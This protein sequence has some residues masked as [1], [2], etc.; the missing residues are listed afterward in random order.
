MGNKIARYL[1]Y[2]S[3]FAKSH[4][5]KVVINNLSAE[6][7]DKGFKLGMQS[8]LHKNRENP[9]SR[10]ITKTIIMVPVRLSSL[11]EYI[12]Y[13]KNNELSDKRNKEVEE[14]L[15]RENGKEFSVKGYSYPA[16]AD[17][18]FLVDYLYSDNV[19]INWRERVICPITELNNRLRATVHFIDYELGINE[20]TVTYLAEQLTPLYNFLYKRHKHIIGSEFLGTGL[21][22][23][24][25]NENGIRHEDATNLSFPDA[26]VDCYLTFECLEHI[27]DYYKTFTEACRILKENGKLF[28]TVPFSPGSYENIIRATVAA[29]GTINHILEPEYHGDPVHSSEGI[30][31]YQHFGWQ[32]FDQLKA[33]G[34]RDAY[35]LSFWSAELG[36]YSEQFIFVAV[37]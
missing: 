12:L 26:S 10:V 33:I 32:M 5:K 27:P 17:V 30:L 29:D 35:A 19:H 15:A 21:Q 25:I 2:A 6:I 24:Y 4:N 18:E 36:Y 31:C 11:E 22:P 7:K 37:K 23:G 3:R 1:S 34:F 14:R 20:H 9:K 28:F 13:K 16:Q 8:F